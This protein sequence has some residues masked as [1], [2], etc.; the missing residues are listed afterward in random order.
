MHCKWFT[1]KYTVDLM[2][3]ESMHNYMFWLYAVTI[4]FRIHIWWVTLFHV[5][6]MFNTLTIND[7]DLWTKT[8]SIT[9]Y[10]YKFVCLR[11][12]KSKIRNLECLKA[13]LLWRH[14]I[15]TRPYIYIHICT[16]ER[17]SLDVRSTL[18][19]EKIL[20]EFCYNFIF[21]Q[22]AHVN[23]III[24]I[25]LKKKRQN[26]VIYDMYEIFFLV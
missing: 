24:I 2:C 16:S 13:I 23:I 1:F 25:Y 18:R 15:H 11:T 21:L 6:L 17:N 3:H 20:I 10:T 8:Y 19:A 7:H 4:Y 9:L 22:F 12:K 26:E 14:S 5:S